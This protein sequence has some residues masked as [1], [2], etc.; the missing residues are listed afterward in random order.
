MLQ[1]LVERGYSDS[2]KISALLLN[3]R[4]YG[5]YI[6]LAIDIGIQDVRSFKF[7]YF[8]CFLLSVCLSKRIISSTSR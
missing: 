7:I 2:G 4:N 1:T 3:N 8:I 5:V 6:T